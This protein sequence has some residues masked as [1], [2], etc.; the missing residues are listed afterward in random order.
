[1]DR[2]SRVGNGVKE[3]Q[4]SAATWGQYFVE[5]RDWLTKQIDALEDM[6]RTKGETRPT[7]DLTWVL[8]LYRL[9][10]D[11][12]DTFNESHAML[13][14]MKTSV[15]PLEKRVRLLEAGPSEAT[16]LPRIAIDWD[17]LVS[18]SKQLHKSESASFHAKGN[19][20]KSRN[21]ETNDNN[22]SR[23]K[24]MSRSL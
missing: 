12:L 16:K 15:E 7:L 18:M 23:S 2:E 20:S 24:R 21:E 17:S 6:D 9:A 11:Y 3:G 22:I 4:E 13:H 5:N 1:M 19:R 14:E 8:S 10:R